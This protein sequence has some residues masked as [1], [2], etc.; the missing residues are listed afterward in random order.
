[1]TTPEESSITEARDSV[2]E[3]RYLWDALSKRDKFGYI[4]HLQPGEVWD[5]TEFHLVGMR[6]V[7]RMMERFRD[8]GR[9]D[10]VHSS[11][12]EIG[13]GVGRFL[14]HLACRFKH[15]Y[16]VDISAQML[17]N[18]EEFCVG[19]PNVSLMANDGRS[20]SGVDSEF[21]EYCVSGGVF[22]HITDSKVIVN[23]VREG[24][25]VLKPGGLFFFQFVGS[26][27]NPVGSGHV[28]AR[29]TAD[30][31]DEGL[32][33]LDYLIREVSTQ[34]GDRMANVVIVLQK[35]ARGETPSAELK[36][37]SSFPLS[38]RPLLEGVYD[39]IKTQTAMHRLQAGEMRRLTFYDT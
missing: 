11:V 28:G 34:P 38:S 10:P 24:L 23:Y 33:D 6:F 9:F 19:I 3:M 15:A 5:M 37:F 13:C 26:K 8:Y 29:V 39:D 30:L 17:K 7:E 31:L 16:G 36:S 14:K 22:Q 12:L 18:A 4:A 25:R 2:G 35:C 1:M 20:L 27:T 32:A 21:V